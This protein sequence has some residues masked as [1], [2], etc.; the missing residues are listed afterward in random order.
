[1]WMPEHAVAAMMFPIVLGVAESLHLEPGKSGYAKALFFALAWGAIIG[2]VATFLGGARAPLALGLLHD[3]FRD[4]DGQAIYQVSFLGWMKA[5]MPIVIIMTGVAVLV[6]VRWIPSEIDDITAATR[7]L[8]DRVAEL[9]PMSS[10]ERRLAVLGVATIGSWIVLGRHVDLAVIAILSAVAV[11]VLRIAEWRHIQGYVNWGVVIMYGG[12]IAL[13]SAMKDTH[14]M[15]WVARQ[16][17]PGG[18]VSPGLLLVGM[19]TLTIA[20]STAISNAAA[21]AVLLPVGYALCSQTDPP[22][23]PLAMTY[24]VALSSGLA[25]ALPISSPPN[26]ICY[27]SGYYGLTDVVKF[28]VPLTIASWVVLVLVVLVY[29]PLVGIEITLPATVAPLSP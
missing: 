14:A 17:L 22:I 23:H 6:V 12:A 21:V 25:F 5:S 29:W 18:D 20:I 9:G 11:S 26:A 1:M 7:M 8:N 27:A 19:A 28:G 4:A 2:G 15:H 3:S 16:V 13:G 10:A 24:V